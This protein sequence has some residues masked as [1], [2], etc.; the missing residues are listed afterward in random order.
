[1]PGTGK[2]IYV[3]SNPTCGNGETAEITEILYEDVTIDISFPTFRQMSS[4]I[5][6]CSTIL[7]AVLHQSYR[8]R[9]R[10]TVHAS[11]AVPV[12]NTVRRLTIA[13]DSHLDGLKVFEGV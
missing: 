2:G 12:R 11:C 3:K 7:R 5:D 6:Y 1:M 4:R 9:I 8:S 10:S 13:A